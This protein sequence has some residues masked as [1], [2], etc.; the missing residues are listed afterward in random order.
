MSKSF[1]QAFWSVVVI[2]ITLI[3]LALIGIGGVQA[4]RAK[5]FTIDVTG[6]AVKTIRSDLAVWSFSVSY[7]GYDEYKSLY[8]KLKPVPKEVEA[9]LKNQG[10]D[11]EEV[12][13][14][15]SQVTSDVESR[16]VD[17]T[18]QDK[19]CRTVVKDKIPLRY[20]T[21]S[22]T[23]YTVSRYFTVESTKVDL[24]IKASNAVDALF[25]RNIVVGDSELRL[26]Y[27]KLAELRLELVKAASEDAF[28]RAQLI[29]QP[30]GRRITMIEDGRLGVFQINAKN[31]PSIS[32]V[33][34]FDTTSLEKDVRAIVNATYR[35][36]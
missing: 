26:I 9:F 14:A 34:N 10:L 23:L 6:S 36:E 5:T 21:V 25:D 35:I 8:A 12:Q 30:V 1:P 16:E 31:D 4:V 27:T 17:C 22:R 7:S 2:G 28:K 13:V 3:A 19:N 15:A 18:A 24:V 29:A 33:G 11:L 20:K 32:D